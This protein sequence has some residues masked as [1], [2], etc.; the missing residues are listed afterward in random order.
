MQVVAIRE[1]KNHLSEYVRRV[2]AGER[3]LI[4]S[5]GEV[6]AELRSPEPADVE[7][8]PLGL[9]E[10]VRRGTAR[11]LVRNDPSQYRTYERALT[12]TTAQ[13][14]LDWDRDDR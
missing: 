6:V 2:R 7:H 13:E 4:T 14:L 5:H 11:G 9:Q 1:L 8:A 12:K 3:L 10:L